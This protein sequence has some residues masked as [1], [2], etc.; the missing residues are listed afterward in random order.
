VGRVGAA[1]LELVGPPVIRPESPGAVHDAARQAARDERDRLGIQLSDY[2]CGRITEA[3]LAVVE[4]R[5]LDEPTPAI[6]VDSEEL[7]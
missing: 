1:L 7:A 5:P 2:A 6:D 4:H 3:V